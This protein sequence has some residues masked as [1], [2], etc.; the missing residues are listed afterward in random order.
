MQDVGLLLEPG[1]VVQGTFHWVFFFFFFFAPH[2]P[3]PA[4]WMSPFSILLLPPPLTYQDVQF[5]I[6][7][8]QTE[9][10]SFLVGHAELG[11]VCIY[12]YIIYINIYN[13]D[14][15]NQIS[16]TYIFFNLCQKCVFKENLIFILRLC[17]VI[18]LYTCT[19]LQH[20]SCRP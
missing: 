9:G 18:H 17:T 19:S 3:F 11:S 20:G 15:K 6:K 13:T 5:T 12:K 2:P 7:Q 8:E 10:F 1:G 4:H 14:L 16:L